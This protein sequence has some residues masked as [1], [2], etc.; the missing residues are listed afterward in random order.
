MAK[1]GLVNKRAAGGAI[2]P[3]NY[4]ANAFIG[5]FDLLTYSC[6]NGAIVL[7]GYPIFGSYQGRVD[8]KRGGGYRGNSRIKRGLFRLRFSSL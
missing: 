3:A 6:S 2:Y 8:R 7:G 5:F 1:E 4:F